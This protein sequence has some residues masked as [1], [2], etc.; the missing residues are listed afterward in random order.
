MSDIQIYTREH[1][2]ITTQIPNEHSTRSGFM[3]NKYD[4]SSN[5]KAAEQVLC[6]SCTGESNYENTRVLSLSLRLHVPF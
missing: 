3:L 6:A 4:S 1:A 5:Y 2:A